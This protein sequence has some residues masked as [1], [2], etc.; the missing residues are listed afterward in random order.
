MHLYLFMTTV[1]YFQVSHNTY[2]YKRGR[3]GI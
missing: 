2:I 1:F 3:T